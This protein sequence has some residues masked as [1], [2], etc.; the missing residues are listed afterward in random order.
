M[1]QKH[2]RLAHISLGIGL[3]LMVVANMLQEGGLTIGSYLMLP[4]YAIWIW[5]CYEYCKAKGQPG[6]KAVYG[7]VFLL[8]L[9]ALI[10]IPDK[11]EVTPRKV[12]RK[13]SAKR[14]K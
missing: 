10:W 5:G 4:A 2:K 11:T 3:V 12:R 1:I 14:R 6:W 9:I 7:V 13:K 8:G